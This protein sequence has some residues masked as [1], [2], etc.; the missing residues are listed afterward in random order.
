[1]STAIEALRPRL[2][3]LQRLALIAG[4]VGLA[5][6]AV[7]VLAAPGWF[8]PAYLVAF[9]FWTG[10]AMGCVAITMLHHL[11]GGTWG[12]MIRR[13]LESGSTTLALMALL[14]LPI[15]PGLKTLYSWTDAEVIRQHAT[16]AHK[17]AYLNPTAWLT[18]GIGYFIVWT[19]FGFLLRRWSARQDE[20]EDYAPTLWCRQLSGPGLAIVFLTASFAAIDWGMSL[21]PEWYSTIY[22]PMLIV[23]WGLETFAFMVAAAILL[24]RYEPLPPGLMTDEF[25][26]LGNLM[27]AFVM[28]W[29]YMSFSQ[30]L[31]IWS[32]NLAEEIP[33]YLRR[34]RGGWQWAAAALIA[35]Q[36]FAPFFFLLFRETKRKTELLLGVSILILM[37]QLLNLAWLVLPAG[38]RDSLHVV[39]P[40]GAV[41]MV[42]LAMA[43]VGGVWMAA[44]VA[45]LKDRSLIPLR[46]P[47]IDP[48]K[49]MKGGTVR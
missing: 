14:F 5:A 10:L 15:F 42:P 19:V 8:Y 47:D 35:F 1:M 18:R 11:T 29:A 33:W 36:F 38:S 24:K 21:E 43:G 39:I 4:V 30:Y 20:T 31:I 49:E 44:F 13:P 45:G 41:L 34:T 37:M 7:G 27:L 46:D 28:L 12:Q 22:G 32:G 26:D 2:V 23:G 25:H 48:A 3:R 40:W 17:I 6:C 9:L 16:V